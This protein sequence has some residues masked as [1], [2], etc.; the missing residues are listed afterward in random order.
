LHYQESRYR[1]ELE[2]AVKIKGTHQRLAPLLQRFIEE[3]LFEDSVD[4][5]DERVTARLADSDVRTYIQ[6]TFIPLLRKKV[7]R[8][9]ERLAEEPPQSVTTW[10]AYQATHSETHPAQIAERTP[11]NLAPCNRQLEVAMTRFLHRADDVAA[12]A[13]NQGPQCLRV[14]ALSAEGRRSLYTA[15]FLIRRSNG[16]YLLVE[17]KGRR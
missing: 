5:Y 10:K 15:D 12:F 16:N 13:K 7:T 4:L 9:Q 8:H 11:F 14:D 2:R 6:A 1:E 17:T 3:V